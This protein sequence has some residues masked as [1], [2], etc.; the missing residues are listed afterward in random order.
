ML[1]GVNVDGNGAGLVV[2][3]AVAVVAVL[4]LV[5]G[6]AVSLS[7]VTVDILSSSVGAT[8][9]VVGVGGLLHV[10]RPVSVRLVGLKELEAAAAAA[11]AAA[12]EA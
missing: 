7:C 2:A 5:D 12:A 3:V 10:F 1:N 9:V 11:A 4:V 6:R 8:A